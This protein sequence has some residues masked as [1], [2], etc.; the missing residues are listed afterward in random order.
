MR[1]LLLPQDEISIDKLSMPDEE[2]HMSLHGARSNTILAWLV[3]EYMTALLT[4]SGHW[5]QMPRQQAAGPVLKLRWTP[6]P[7]LP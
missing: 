4:P 2:N 6:L 1:V 5:G 3:K 7:G